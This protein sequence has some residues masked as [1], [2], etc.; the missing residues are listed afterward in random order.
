M[1]D[2]KTKFL[3]GLER[4][5][6]SKFGKKLSEEVFGSTLR[7]WEDR[8]DGAFLDTPNTN[9]STTRWGSALLGAVI[10]EVFV[11]GGKFSVKDRL[12]GNRD[13]P[14]KTLA[15]A[16]TCVSCFSTTYCPRLSSIGLLPRFLRL[17]K[18][19]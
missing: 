18:W 5:L 14:R 7:L 2:E 6:K 9:G 12:S 16:S 17:Q 11:G 10:S 19:A 8:R 13:L 3:T 15:L 1:E 4:S